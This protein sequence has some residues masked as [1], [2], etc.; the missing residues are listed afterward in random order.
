MKPLKF[1]IKWSFFGLIWLI[2][3]AIIIVIFNF[4]SLPSLDHL[5][6]KSGKQIV[7]INYQDGNYLAS[8]GKIYDSQ[9]SYHQFPQYL[10]DAVIATEDRKFFKHP[11]IDIF[12]IMRAFIANQKAGRVVQG[13]STI[14]QQ[15]A[16]MM[17]LSSKRT[18][19]RKIEE[20]LL[21]LQLEHKFSKEQI[22][23]FYLNKAYFGSGNYGVADASRYYFAKDVAQLNLNEAA[24]LAG[25]LKSPNKFSPKNNRNLAEERSQTVIKN[26]VAAGFLDVSDIG[27][28]DKDPDYKI[29]HLQKLYFVDYVLEQFGDFLDSNSLSDKQITINTTLNNKFQQA[30]EDSIDELSYKNSKKIAKS[31]IAAIIMAKDGA[32]LAMA[33]G[34]D[35][36]KSQFNRAIHSKRQA[37]SLFKTF[38]YLAAF[39]RGAKIDDIFEDKKITIGDWVPQNYNNKYYG[40]VTV[41]QA[42]A[43]SL[44]SVAVQLGM[45][46]GSD[47]VKS[48]ARKC[49]I[50]SKIKDNDP[51][52]FLGTTAVS[53]LEI[54]SAYATI[55][56]DG[57]PVMPYAI[58]NIEGSLGNQIYKLE[59]SGFG[60]IISQESQDN[61]TRILRQVVATGTGKNANIA[62]NIY[63][64]TG[65]SQDS[66]DAWFVGFNND[67]VIGIWIGNDDNSP[68]N[69]ITGGSLPAKLFAKIA[70]KISR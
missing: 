17:F 61:I 2:I 53:L 39:E 38:A 21:A 69:K 68:T 15:L 34:K 22:L 11:G 64:K 30:L 66:R 25:I 57:K 37:G 41:E 63:G 60:Q 46:V 20:L 23:T 59:S 70:T 55:A 51:T 13:G 27:Q 35:Y 12:G 44:N 54:T 8:R 67:Y 62:N 40:P 5:Q 52:I 3:L 28:I 43:K 58:N 32:I 50:T 56:N 18:L 36:Q 7:Q 26:M 16:K 47:F 6:E 9:V 45:A 14:T 65:T 19:K 4:K 48:I 31:Q 29:D 10:I 1:V 24:I 42:F 49:G 33:G